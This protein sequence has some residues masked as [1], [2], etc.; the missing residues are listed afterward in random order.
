MLLQLHIAR[1]LQ[2]EAV[3]SRCSWMK[4]P[5]PRAVGA[6]QAW[7]AELSPGP[8]LRLLQR[9]QLPQEVVML[10]NSED[11]ATGQPGADGV[12]AS[13]SLLWL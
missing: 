11:G 7:K 10:V 12:Q 1:L 4:T 5:K 8:S 3:L 6:S 9:R 2:Q 13:I